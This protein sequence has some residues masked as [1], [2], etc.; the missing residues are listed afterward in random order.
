MEP[1]NITWED[2]SPAALLNILKAFLDH[3]ADQIQKL[4][5]LKS[6]NGTLY[7]YM[8]KLPAPVNSGLP[9]IMS[10]GLFL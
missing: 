10:E 9:A 2:K 8:Q 7:V 5:D 3:N 1:S 6:L 4:S